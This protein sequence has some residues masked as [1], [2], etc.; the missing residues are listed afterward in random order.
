VRSCS[1]IL[2]TWFV[3]S[4]SA[5]AAP[6]TDWA[7]KHARFRVAVEVD[8]PTVPWP[9]VPAG[10]WIDGE[11][12]LR[13]AG[14]TGDTLNPASI[15]VVPAGASEPVPHH[16]AAG[17]AADQS[18]HVWWR[19]ADPKTTTYHVYFDL[20]QPSANDYA[21]RSGLIG[22]GDALRHNHGQPGLAQP[23]ALHS[24]MWLIDFDGDGARDLIGFGYREYEYGE[25]LTKNMGNAVYFQKNL[26]T[27]AQP[28]FAP[29]HRVKDTQGNYISTPLLPQN[30]FPTDW[31]GD[32]QTDFIGTGSTNELLL[33]KN[34]GQRDA[35]GLSLLEPARVVAKLEGVSDFRKAAHGPAQPARYSTRGLFRC[36][37][38]GDGDQDLIVTWRTV[39]ILRKDVDSKRGVIPYGT[40]IHFFELWRNEGDDADGNPRFAE[41]VVLTDDSGLMLHSR[42]AASGGVIYIDW[43][44]DGDF[45][46]LFH[47]DDNNLPIESSR[48]MF[49]EN[50]GTREHP[51]FLMPLPLQKARS[52]GQAVDWNDDGRVDLFAGNEFFENVNPR[53]ATRPVPSTTPGKS[54]APHAWS[55]PK[56]VSRGLAQQVQ[57]DVMSYF[58]IAV[59]WDDDGD[60]DLVQGYQSYLRLMRNIGTTREPVF[61]PPVFIEAD[62][63]RL[64]MLNHLDPDADPPVHWGPQGPAEL[65]YG[66]LVPSMIDFDGDGDLD[67]FVT[68]QRWQVMYFENVG[69]RSAPR[70]AKGREVRCD[71]NPHEFSWRSKVSLGDIDGDGKP[72]LVVTSD[73]DNSFYPYRQAIDQ[74]DENALEL[75]RA[76]APLQLED[77][78]PVQGW[79]G[80]QNNNGD[81]HSQLVDWDGD[82]D[83]DLLNGT[84]YAVWYYENVGDKQKPRFAHRG[85][86]EAGGS[87]IQTFRHAGSFDAADWTG[88]GRVDLIMGAECPSDQPEGAVLHFFDRAYIEN[89]LP[90]AQIIGDVE[91]QPD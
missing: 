67:L 53:S 12:L 55:Y 24:Q 21:A 15:R 26:G 78:Q 30:M 16:A 19:V 4:M 35:K 63:S 27:S 69:T 42:S 79:H 49:A 70:F 74:P 57:P 61:E 65:K 46:L 56:L 51:I 33:W 45:D 25:E 1:A 43:D 75:I 14:V 59:D 29:R 32:G 77:G 11:R 73:E 81:N 31:D 83:L 71:G 2:L 3:G 18:G 22:I 76:D 9:D 62:G 54:R 87:A 10:V 13:E 90:T 88:D 86:M 48:M 66:W 72:E 50:D 37:F 20:G 44:G 52:S 38:E 82:G 84:L 7:V 23:T 85:K 80:G 68:S 58:A 36:D 8:A 5:Q 60:L 34:S 89:R 39:G 91:K 6:P 41:P 17:L 47:D 64:Q 40:P 28:L